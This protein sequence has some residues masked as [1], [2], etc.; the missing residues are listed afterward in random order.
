MSSDRFKQY[1]ELVSQGEEL[2]RKDLE[3][4]DRL[5]SAY[6]SQKSLDLALDWGRGQASGVRGIDIGVSLQTALDVFAVTGLDPTG[7]VSDDSDTRLAV[8]LS[9]PPP[10]SIGGVFLT[11]LHGFDH[12]RD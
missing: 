12:D 11:S 8:N 9:T 6:G 7:L 1:E 3:R 4:L 5:G 2:T 10:P